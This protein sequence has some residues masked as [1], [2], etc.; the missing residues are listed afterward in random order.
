METHKFTYFSKGIMKLLWSNNSHLLLI[1]L[2]L[3]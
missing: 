3:P 1:R 2:G